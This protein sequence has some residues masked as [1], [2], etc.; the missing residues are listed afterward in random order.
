MADEPTPNSDGILP[1]TPSRPYPDFPQGMV[2][3]GTAKAPVQSV[4]GGPPPLEASPAPPSSPSQP[5]S[6]GS[7]GQDAKGLRVG[8]FAQLARY[9]AGI[10]L[11]VLCGWGLI[12]LGFA[13]DRRFAWHLSTEVIVVVF[14]IISLALFL[15]LQNDMWLTRFMGLKLTAYSTPVTESL[16]FCLLGPAGLLLRSSV[17]EKPAGAKAPHN[18]DGTREIVETI[19]FVVVL[20]LLLKTFVVEAFVI[21][22]GSMATTLLGYH[23]KVTCEQCRKT[24]LVNCSSEVEPQNGQTQTVTHATCPNCRFRNTLVP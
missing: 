7:A 15:A 18:V 22:T 21:P 17:H 5:G 11:I 8:E 16:F 23:K 2:Y 10:V 13:L 20:V 6:P 14:G 9:L 24:F 3:A 19:V 12:G 4:A 1:G